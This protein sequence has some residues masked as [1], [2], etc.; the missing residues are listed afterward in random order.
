MW[1]YQQSFQAMQNQAEQNNCNEY[2]TQFW[3]MRFQQ[4][5]EAGG[6]LGVGVCAPLF[7][8]S[9][10]SCQVKGKTSLRMQLEVYPLFR[11]RN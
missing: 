3:E 7:G 6:E 1:T 5:A 2:Y 11:I 4:V 9:H 10:C 8:T